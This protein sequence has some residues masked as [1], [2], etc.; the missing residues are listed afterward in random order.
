TNLAQCFHF[1]FLHCLLQYGARPVVGLPVYAFKENRMAVKFF[2][3]EWYLARNPDVAELVASGG[4]TAQEHYEVFGQN[5]G[6]SPSPLF[7]PGYYLD[8]NVD[9]ATAVA[10]GHTTAYAHFE[11]FGHLEN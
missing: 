8:H 10:L 11:E 1:A 3:E 2:D 9:V 6:R 4:M 5:E 7:D